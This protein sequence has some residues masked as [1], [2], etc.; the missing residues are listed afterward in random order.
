MVILKPGESIT[1]HASVWTTDIAVNRSK[2]NPRYR[3]ASISIIPM[4]WTSGP[5]TAWAEP[6]FTNDPAPTD[7]T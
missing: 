7:V 4:G 3:N 2:W 1:A 6:T 5:G